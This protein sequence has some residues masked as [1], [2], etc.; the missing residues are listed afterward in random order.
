MNKQIVEDHN[1]LERSLQIDISNS[2]GKLAILGGHYALTS[3]I[4][5]AISP[6]S[7]SGFGIFPL[8]TFELACQLIQFSKSIHKY[9][10]LILLVD[11][12]SQMPDKQ[13]YMRRENATTDEIR[14][15]VDTYFQN[16]SIPSEYRTHMHKYEI[17]EKDF[18]SSTQ[19]VGWQESC[20][21]EKFFRGTGLEPGC[22][23]EY[24]CVLE[25]LA[26]QNIKELVAFIP[27]RCQGPTCN[28]LKQYN[29]QKSNPSLKVT[30]VYF[31]SNEEN[32]TSQDLL[33]EMNEKY[34][35]ILVMKE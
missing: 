35:G 30:H 1:E 13:W 34:G 18:L 29:A 22:A 21:R 12:Y 7:Q 14:K 2:T 32:F 17:S 26:Q 31:S 15:K 3:K 23:G 6:D 4:E 10:Q 9:S 24:R 33:D 25:E 28:A 5:P 8:H 19:G 11:D 16:F 27:L 20:Y